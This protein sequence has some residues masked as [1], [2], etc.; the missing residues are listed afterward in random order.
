M[1]IG[2]RL[3]NRLNIGGQTLQT[4]DKKVDVYEL[5]RCYFMRSIF[6]AKLEELYGK[7]TE[8]RLG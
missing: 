2:N 6:L 5:N 8:T 1:C 7:A 3:L 4:G